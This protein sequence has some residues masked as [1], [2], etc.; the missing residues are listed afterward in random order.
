MRVAVVTASDRCARGESV[1]ESGPAAAAFCQRLGWEVVQQR[2][3]PDER[4]LLRDALREAADDLAVDLVLTTGGTGLGPRD[5]TP[6]ATADVVDRWA[7]GI[8][9]SLRASSL[10]ITPFAM[11]SRGNA[12][13]R[14]TTLII[15]LP[16]SPR[17]VLQCLEVLEPV[18]AHAVAMMAG[19]GH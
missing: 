4:S 17:A 5:V 7:P 3:L 1:D 10:K 2:L 12:G 13:L 11:L 15:N 16:G 19:E 6:E 8:A 18:L 14:G 9:E